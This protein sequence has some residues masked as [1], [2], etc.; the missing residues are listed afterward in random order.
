[1]S[2]EGSCEGSLWP[3][4]GSCEFLGEVGVLCCFC[5]WHWHMILLGLV[6]ACGP[7]CDLRHALSS[8]S[9]ASVQAVSPLGFPL[10]FV[11]PLRMF[12]E[13]LRPEVASLS[14]VTR[15][16]DLLGKVPHHPN[17]VRLRG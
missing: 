14:L 3:S 2:S 9:L 8:L 10:C 4:S 15:E 13:C 5:H 12:R 17:I 7:S 16:I 6:S 11:A 1:M